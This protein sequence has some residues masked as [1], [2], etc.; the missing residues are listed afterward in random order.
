MQS[1]GSRHRLIFCLFC[2]PT[3]VCVLNFCFNFSFH[4]IWQ[5]VCVNVARSNFLLLSLYL[6]FYA[7]KCCVRRFLMVWWCNDIDLCLYVA[8]QQWSTT[9]LLSLLFVHNSCSRKNITQNKKKEI[10]WHSFVLTC[11]CISN[12]SIFS[13][14]NLMES[15]CVCVCMCTSLYSLNYVH[16]TFSPLISSVSV[17]FD[18]FLH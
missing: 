7:M 3:M 9:K 13:S 17:L 11:Q 15:M 5:F 16:C 12:D 4:D 2:T 18:F 1:S 10:H 6:Y 8:V 14:L